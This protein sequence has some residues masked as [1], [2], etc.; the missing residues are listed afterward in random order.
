MQG[1]QPSTVLSSMKGCSLHPQHYIYLYVGTDRYCY[2]S[3]PGT[4]N[5]DG[6]DEHVPMSTLGL[7]VSHLWYQRTLLVGSLNCLFYFL[8]QVLRCV[9]IVSPWS[10]SQGGLYW[11]LSWVSSNP[12]RILWWQAQR[13][14][15]GSKQLG[16]LVA[17]LQRWVVE[18][19]AS[20]LPLVFYIWISKEF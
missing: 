14:W 11:M 18:T 20:G 3:Q 6:E 4:R 19:M 15:F 10:S 2:H 12:L 8:T 9:P 7:L 5:Q 16:V 1:F 13:R 17:S